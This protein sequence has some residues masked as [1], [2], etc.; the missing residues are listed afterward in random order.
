MPE[1]NLPKIGFGTYQL[2]GDLCVK[3]VEHAIKVGYRFI[4]TAEYY[5]NEKEVGKAIKNMQISR[6][7]LIIATKLWTDHLGKNQVQMATEDCLNR[8]GLDQIDIL[9]IHWPGGNYDP[10]ITLPQFDTLVDDNLIKYIGI[11]NFSIDQIIEAQKFTKHPLLV[12]QIEVHPRNYNRELYDYMQQKQMQVVA[13]SP[14]DRGKILNHSLL[15]KIGNKYAISESEVVLAWLI[16]KNIVPIPKSGNFTHIEENY[17]AIS[18]QL[19]TE[20][21][22]EIDTLSVKN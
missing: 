18:I 7:N 2:H 20:D 10:E 3:S 19:Q 13:Y 12:N 15:S 14:L 8:L 6:K 9:Y 1:F 17:H 22:E 5:E 11:S 16:S 4:D 21:I